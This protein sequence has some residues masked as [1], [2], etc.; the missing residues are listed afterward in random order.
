MK[1][2]FLLVS[3]YRIFDTLSR[4]RGVLGFGFGVSSTGHHAWRA[5]RRQDRRT[6]LFQS[7]SSSKNQKKHTVRTMEQYDG[8]EIEIRSRTVR[9]QKNWQITI[10]EKH[11]PASIIEHYWGMKSNG[12]D[13]LDPF[14]LVSWPGSVVAAREL[15]KYQ[16]MIQNST[17]LVLGAGTGIE[18][19]AIAQLGAK[20]VIATDIHPTTL[21]LLEYGA[22]EAGFEK[23]IEAEGE[24]DFV[25]LSL[26]V[27]LY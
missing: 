18:A 2:L 12:L 14:G 16:S 1:Q 27:I 13:S 5:T 21:Q 19:Q 20:K 22:K 7:T 23:I 11:E 8:H 17:V 4:C 26:A 15:E 6:S 24:K 9:I 3:L 25:R 10:W